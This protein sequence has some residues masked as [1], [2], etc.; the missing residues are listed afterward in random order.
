[1]LNQQHL[2]TFQARHLFEKEIDVT[3]HRLDMLILLTARDGL[4]ILIGRLSR[5]VRAANLIE[6]KDAWRPFAGSECLNPFI[7]GDAKMSVIWTI[8]IG[9]VAG[10][11][12]KFVMPGDN[13][14]SGFI[15]SPPS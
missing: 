10:V 8:V 2:E 9:F 14:P 15:S 5:E 11:V 4:L 1:V 3:A 12:A 7:T 6:H 13:E